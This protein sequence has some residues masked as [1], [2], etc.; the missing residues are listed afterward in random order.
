MYTLYQE[1]SDTSNGTFG[2][3][4][5]T[6]HKIE[7][8]PGVMQE[9]GL[10]SGGSAGGAAERGGELKFYGKSNNYGRRRPHLIIRFLEDGTKCYDTTFFI[11][12]S[13]QNKGRNVKGLVN[14]QLIQES[15]QNP[16]LVER[17]LSIDILNE[18]GSLK[19]KI[20]LIKPDY[21]W[22]WN[23][24]NWGGNNGIWN[25]NSNKRT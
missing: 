15:P 23:S 5:R 8:N 4:E 2:I 7:K 18:D 19:K 25:W 6:V 13:H 16:A 21:K 22:K 10:M 11:E 9:F 24:W 20:V 1:L 14:L 17:Y 12:Q 3:I